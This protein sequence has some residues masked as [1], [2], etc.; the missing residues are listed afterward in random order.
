MSDQKK[1]LK[2][3]AVLTQLVSGVQDRVLWLSN[4]ARELKRSVEWVKDEVRLKT[5]DLQHSI[6]DQN[7]ILEQMRSQM[8]AE[9]KQVRSLFAG[10]TAISADVTE[11]EDKVEREFSVVKSE[12][13]R[14]RT[15]GVQRADLQSKNLYDLGVKVD[16]LVAA[17]QKQNERV[18]K[19]ESQVVVGSIVP[20]AQVLDT[21][22]RVKELEER[23]KIAEEQIKKLGERAILHTACIVELK[24]QGSKVCPAWHHMIG[25][26]KR[27]AVLEDAGKNFTKAYNAGVND[28]AHLRTME[29]WIQGVRPVE[30]GLQL[31]LHDTKP[32]PSIVSYCLETTLNMLYHALPSTL[33]LMYNP[34]FQRNIKE[35]GFEFNP[36]AIIALVQKLVDEREQTKVS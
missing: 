30:T 15:L 2:P 1:T 4:F 12:A 35:A 33:R 8:D 14:Q 16:Q 25:V 28:P 17:V 6:A 27:V 9:T 11:I 36:E 5:G 23:L 34:S 20:S 31:K 21:M 7:E 24:D 22:H 29:D 26:E 13:E 32:E 18:S 19:V 3:V 10:Q